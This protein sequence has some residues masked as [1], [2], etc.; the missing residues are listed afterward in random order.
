M[1][2]R[3]LPGLYPY[4]R[5]ARGSLISTTI[6]GLVTEKRAVHLEADILWRQK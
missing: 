3:E 1:L 5:K 6:G 4:L 2:I